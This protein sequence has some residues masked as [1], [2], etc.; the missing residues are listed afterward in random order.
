MIRAASVYIKERQPRFITDA[1]LPTPP[2]ILPALLLLNKRPPPP[3][4]APPAKRLQTS[5]LG[6][7]DV[8]KRKINS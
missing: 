6:E 5:A 7:E 4:T 1:A 3:I 2:T 8:Q